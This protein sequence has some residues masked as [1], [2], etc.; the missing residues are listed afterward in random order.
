MDVGKRIYPLLGL[1]LLL[2][3]QSRVGSPETM[4]TPPTKMDSTG[5]ICVYMCVCVHLCAYMYIHTHVYNN[6][7]R[8]EANNEIGGGHKRGSRESSWEG[9][10]GERGK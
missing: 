1:S 4:Y 9:L 2:V 5:C 7:Q 6:N 3:V 8:K 10:E